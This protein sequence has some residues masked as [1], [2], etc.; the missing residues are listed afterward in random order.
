MPI[1]SMMKQYNV[2]LCRGIECNCCLDC[3]LLISIF[4]PDC[5]LL[6]ATAIVPRSS[7]LPKDKKMMLFTL[8]NLFQVLN[9][10][11]VVG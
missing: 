10:Y 6:L 1:I 3:S 9:M 11:P 4:F 7:F 2:L 5:K 8:Q